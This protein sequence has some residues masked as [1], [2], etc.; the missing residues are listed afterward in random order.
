MKKKPILLLLL[1]GLGCA[2]CATA[3][4]SVSL[5]TLDLTKTLPRWVAP[6][7]DRSQADKPL[8]IAG[9][10]FA[11][12]IGS[13]APSTWW[14]E[15]GGG[16]RFSARVGV[17]DSAPTDAAVNFLILG[18]GRK[19][20]ESGPMQRGEE[21][22]SVEVPTVGVH[23][24]LLKL[25]G[26][27]D[28]SE[29][30]RAG[31]YYTAYADWADARIDFVGSSPKAV[32]RPLPK[33]EF[34]ILTPKP[35]PQPRINGPRIY[36]CRP[37]HPFLYRIPTQGERPMTFSAEGLP[38][39]LTLDAAGG[40]I[41]GEAPARGEYSVTLRARNRHGESVRSFK[42]VS[43]DTLS[44]TPS[45]GW[46]H[47]YTDYFRV[48]DAT[49][50]NAADIMVSS[51]MADVGYQY[52]N[53]DDCWMNALENADPLRTGPVREGNGMIR[54]NAHFP[55]MKGLT[56][57]IHGKGLKAGIYST[58]GRLTC[59]HFEGSY[60]H[61]AQDAK[62]FADWG[63]DFLKYDWCSY[64]KIARA[65]QGTPREIMVRP[66]A[67]MGGFLREQKRDILYNLCQYGRE[68]VWTWGADAGAQSWRTSI[69]LGLE[70]DRVFEV[71]L[72]NANHREW[73]KPGSWNDP[74]YVQIGFF[75]DPKA[76]A[77]TKG[78]EPVPVPLSPSEQYAFMSLWSLSAAP[79]FFGGD[80][81]HLDEFAISVL[82][83]PEVIDIDQDPLG[84]C[85]RVVR[86]D[87]DRF[88]MVK[89][90]ADG[91]KAV[92]LCNAGELP[93]EVTATWSEIGIAGKHTVRDVWRQKDIGTVNTEFKA[94]VPR[95]GV[96]LVRILPSALT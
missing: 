88:I 11:H 50:R 6:K 63:F 25:T 14:I 15:V 2:A 64:E 26:V 5:D 55:D 27:G 20:W 22:K 94:Q 86:I 29:V 1:F 28:A 65:A 72:A 49:I 47:W 81:S 19:I 91:S 21:A 73:S 68:E 10:T 76:Y 60:G 59:G 75:G 93:E 30:E 90:L 46:N 17:D 34:F 23:L 40:I 84:Q 54:P 92:G 8:S 7:A 51:G 48:T 16:E 57:Y 44:L 95:R 38:P 36:G 83:N 87:A 33:E 58:P 85:A 18:D 80:I 35:G 52:V 96:V 13:R 45:M 78:A 9:K 77:Q 71:A 24:L 70:I 67:L 12:G 39:S 69:D 37:G 89:D 82:C 66:F 56:D 61:E 43:G 32:S 53:I 62:Q 79:L 42:V 4:E 31:Y 3:M 41:A 74:D